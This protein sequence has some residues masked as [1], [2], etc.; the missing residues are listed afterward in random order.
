MILVTVGHQTPFDRLIEWVDRWAATRPDVRVVAQIGEGVYVPS[1]VEWC[2]W[3]SPSEFG[4]SLQRAGVLVAHAGTGTIMQALRIGLPL[5]VVPRLSANRETRNDHQIGTARYFAERGLLK[6]AMTEEEFEAE[7]EAMLIRQG[8]AR[9]PLIGS[10]ASD[11][12]NAR[13]RDF[14]SS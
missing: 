7:I 1:H 9:L 3:M 2:R 13:I 12:L 14:L 6:S 8:S 5:L 11:E 4:L 10:D